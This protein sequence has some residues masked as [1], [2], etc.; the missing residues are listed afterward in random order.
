MFPLL[1]LL[2]LIPVAFI[3]PVL[4][5][6]ERHS[7]K[8][9][10]LSSAI[11]FLLT[12]YVFYVSANSGL[13]ALSFSYA[14]LPSLGINVNFQLTGYSG[15]FLVLSA[16][17]LLSASVCAGSFVKESHRIYGVLFLLT[18]ASALGIFLSGSLFLFFAFWELCDV[19]MF[20]MIHVFGG[21]ERRYA[22]IKFLIYS[23]VASL[24]LLLGI[25]V[26][27][28]NVPDATRSTSPQS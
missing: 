7:L 22:A 21:Q 18:E 20:F 14:Y 9:A 5:A 28:A 2:V 27:Y 3:I 26:I 13:V 4:L 23:T 19:A 10:T 25:M 24:A 11:V 16:V 12:L 8:I 15:I 6:G 17:V 1:P